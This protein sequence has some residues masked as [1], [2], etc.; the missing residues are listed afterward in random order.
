MVEGVGKDAQ[1]ATQAWEIPIFM[2]SEDGESVKGKYRAPVIPG[3]TLPPL[4]GLKALRAMGAVIDCAQGKM[5]LPGPGGYSFQLSPGSRMFR[6]SLSD[7]GHLILPVDN[8]SAD[9]PEQQ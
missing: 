9:E 2:Q 7:S 1:Q 8:L 6:L 4:L 3:S 5:L